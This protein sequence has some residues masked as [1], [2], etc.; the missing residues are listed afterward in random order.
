MSV[1]HFLLTESDVQGTLTLSDGVLSTTGELQIHSQSLN[2]ERRYY[3]LETFTE[4]KTVFEGGRLLLDCSDL[5]TPWTAFPLELQAAK[6][7]V[8]FFYLPAH[9]KGTP[10]L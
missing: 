8:P 6:E 10:T 9:R 5:L 7:K 2:T 4:N 1:I 3:H